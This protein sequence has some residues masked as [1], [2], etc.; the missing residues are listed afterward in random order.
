MDRKERMNH[1]LPAY[2]DD[3]FYKALEHPS[4]VVLPIPVTSASKLVRLFEII[5][6]A[7][8]TVGFFTITQNFPF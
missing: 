4:S 8:G 1:K 6:K 2:F 7:F 5:K 3:V